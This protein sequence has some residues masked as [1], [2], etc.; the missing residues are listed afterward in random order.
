[1][2]AS[3]ALVLIANYFDLIPFW[4]LNLIQFLVDV[5]DV[6]HILKAL[7]LSGVHHIQHFICIKWSSFIKLKG[8]RQIYLSLF[9][10]IHNPISCDSKIFDFAIFPVLILFFRC[11]AGFSEYLQMLNTHRGI[12]I[13]TF[14]H[15]LPKMCCHS[16]GIANLALV[17]TLIIVESLLLEILM[18]SK[19]VSTGSLIIRCINLIYASVFWEHETVLDFFNA[20]FYVNEYINNSQSPVRLNWRRFCF[21]WRAIKFHRCVHLSIVLTR[22]NSL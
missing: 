21:L 13:E 14:Q 6:D 17:M 20:Y 9:S 10:T 11:L 2:N 8:C 3:L 1:M 19:A 15:L 5:L 4:P 12:S 16:S 7:M 18:Y 22:E